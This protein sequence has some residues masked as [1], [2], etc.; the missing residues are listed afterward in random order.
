MPRICVALVV[1]ALMSVGTVATSIAVAKTAAAPCQDA[2]LLPTATN[3]AAINAVTLCLVDR[4][5]AAH[6]LPMLRANRELQTV[7][8]TQAVEM[9]SQ[10]FFSHDSP[11]GQTPAARVASTRYPV[12]ARSLSTAQN[13]GWGT[14]AYATPAHMVA[15]WMASPPHRQIILT[16]EYRDAGVGVAVPV[17]SVVGHGEPGATYAIEFG[18]RH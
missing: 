15:A 18:A 14:G 12:H 3:M 7:A 17:P 1:V 5:R 2:N 11:S 16:G 4:I 6:H 9:V 10:D 8:I 13:I